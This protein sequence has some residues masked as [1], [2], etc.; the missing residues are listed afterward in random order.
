MKKK[1]TLQFLTNSMATFCFA[2]LI[3]CLS[4]SP[5]TAQDDCNGD[6]YTS[7]I[8]TNVERVEDILFGENIQPTLFDENATQELFL[9]FYHAPADELE[10]RP[11]I[12][13]AFGG[14]FVLGSKQ[15][16]D[17]VELCERFT[18]YGYANA[19]IDYRLT[20]DLVINGSEENGGKAVLKAVHDMRAAIRF[21]YKDAATDNIYQIDTNRIYVAGVSAGAI[22]AVHTTYLDDI[23]E[24]PDFLIEE[25]E[26]T[27]GLEGLSGNP[28]YSSKV[29]GA[30][31]LCGAIADTSWMT[32]NDLPIV[33]VHGNADDVVP[34]GSEILTL[35]NLNMLLH[36]SSSIHQ[37]CELLDIE[38]DFYTFE[39]AAHTPF[40][41]GETT[42]AYMDTTF[43]VLSSFMATQVC[44]DIVGLDTPSNNQSL[45]LN[46]S[47]NP[48]YGQARVHLPT[49]N[50][51]TNQE[52][53]IQCFNNQGQAI[54]F[55][56]VVSGDGTINLTA[57]SNTASGLYYLNVID[58]RQG[59]ALAQAKFMYIH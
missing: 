17:I 47:P 16:P 20:Q 48:M 25:I 27:G 31:N 35:F 52:L 45:Q 32:P 11:L 41:L 24:A 49:F 4:S 18:R 46:V 51:A 33:S 38:N 7:N 6:R 9:D 26:N 34:Y 15:S 8:F 36:G 37:Q 50:N 30:L 12:I 57:N 53:I 19:S 54:N 13:W 58:A 44:S 14:A 23:N 22:A 42:N 28:G 3:I 10:K 1:S 59:I 21:F 55:N 43:N 56:T 2:I 29:A 40:A 39:G 5:S